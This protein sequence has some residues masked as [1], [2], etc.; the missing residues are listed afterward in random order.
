M[1]EGAAPPLA[2]AAAPEQPLP[3]YWERLSKEDQKQYLQLRTELSSP[4]FS[5][6]RGR[7][8][9]QFNG[10]LGMIKSFVVR[11]NASDA[12]RALVCGIHWLAGAIAVNI[13]QLQLLT[14][15]CKS[16]IN[17]S[18]SHLGYGTVP[19]REHPTSVLTATFP[20]M[21][22]SYSELRRWTVRQLGPPKGAV[23][24]PTE[25]LGMV[26]VVRQP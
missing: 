1:A 16:S 8:A 6:Q 2:V 10:I 7:S 5:N 9:A 20:W 25:V 24:V 11:G 23:V 17:G 4:V 12:N 18:L 3:G 21:K 19:A 26:P 15:K 13:R 14:S 22:D